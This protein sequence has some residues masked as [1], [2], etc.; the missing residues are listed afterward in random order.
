MSIEE[1][2]DNFNDNNQTK[3]NLNK[4]T[5]IDNMKDN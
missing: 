5:N 2:V 1:N 4:D 3:N